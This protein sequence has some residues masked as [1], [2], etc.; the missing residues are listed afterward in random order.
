ML[1]KPAAAFAQ[2]LGAVL[3]FFGFGA[4]VDGSYWLFV[5]GAALLLWGGWAARKRISEDKPKHP[6][7][8]R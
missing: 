2:L 3:M 6:A 4:M 5:V 1:T 7:D 8:P